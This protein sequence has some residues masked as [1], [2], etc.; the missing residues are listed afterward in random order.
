MSG[1]DVQ[2]GCTRKQAYLTK[3]EAKRANESLR[4][5]ERRHGRQETHV[6]HCP[7]EWGGC[8]HYHIGHPGGWE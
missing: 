5:K 1:W 7:P 4:T 8:G 6:Y 2:H 3:R